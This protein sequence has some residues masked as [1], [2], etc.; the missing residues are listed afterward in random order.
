MLCCCSRESSLPH[1][2]NCMVLLWLCS[3]WFNL[4]RLK[5]FWIAYKESNRIDWCTSSGQSSGTGIAGHKSWALTPSTLPRSLLWGQQQM[6][7]ISATVTEPV[8]HQSHGSRDGLH[9]VA[10]FCPLIYEQAWG[11]WSSLLTF[12]GALY[13]S[14]RSR[15]VQSSQWG[16]SHSQAGKQQQD[17]LNLSRKELRIYSFLPLEWNGILWYFSPHLTTST[18]SM[19]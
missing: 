13:I 11:L 7:F 19:A 12:Y 16:G 15:P 2:Y 1:T 5:S 9:S 8:S 14:K 10:D 6:A 4:P 18:P 3:H 17:I